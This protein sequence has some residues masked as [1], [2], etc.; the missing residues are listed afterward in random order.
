[1]TATGKFNFWRQAWVPASVEWCD[2]IAI[3][4]A[5]RTE[6]LDLLVICYLAKKSN[7]LQIKCIAVTV[8]EISILFCGMKKRIAILIGPILLSC[9][10]GFSQ[11]KAAKAASQIYE[12]EKAFSADCEKNKLKSS[13]LRVLHDSS[14]VFIPHPVNAK[15][16]YFLQL[17]DSKDSINLTWQPEFVEASADGLLGYSWG[18]WVRKD[19][20]SDSISHYGHYMSIWS[21]DGGAWKMLMD[22]G[23]RYSKKPNKK[24]LRIY[25]GA[26]IQFSNDPSIES[27]S[28]ELD[29]MTFTSSGAE[30][31]DEHTV[32]FRMGQV[33]FLAKDSIPSDIHNVKD[34]KQLGRRVANSGDLFYEYGYYTLSTNTNRGYF[35]RIWRKEAGGWRLHFDLLLP[36]SERGA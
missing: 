3:R 4:S 29:R 11:N 31:F 23:V 7:Y 21:Q 33:P 5:W 6:R 28:E 34:W 19:K 20:P 10:A 13:F 12:V 36:L 22:R 2:Y 30:L 25:P 26:E 27:R 24:E 9:V 1:V 15:A 35:V 8:W 16:L 17:D 32:F 14:V 18:P